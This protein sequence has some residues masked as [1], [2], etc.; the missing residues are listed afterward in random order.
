MIIPPELAQRIVDTAQG[1]VHRNVNIMNREGIIIGTAQPHRRRTF[2][3]GALDV[4][5]MG[6]AV[7][8]AE[9]Q[10]AS[11]PGSRPGVN[12]PIVLE[13]QIIGVIG[14]TGDPAEVR[15]TARLIK[16]ITELIL[17]REL[18]QNMALH[19]LKSTEQIMEYLLWQNTAENL[20]RIRR[21]ARD[22]G[23]DLTLP[24]AAAVADV[25][26]L[27][28]DF[29]A[30]YGTSELVQE[31]AAE[32]ILQRLSEQGLAGPQ[33]AAVIM[34]G[35]LILL[36]I[37]PAAEAPAASRRLAGDLAR[38][39]TEWT[40]GEVFCGIG[41]LAETA[42]DY[43]H[44]H[45]QAEYCL[46]AA[47]SDAPVRSIYEHGLSVGYV[48]HEAASGPAGMV[49]KPLRAAVEGALTQKP[50]LARTL[51]ALLARNLD[52]EA[53]ADALDVHR[54]TL[55]YRLGR[56]REATGLDPMRRLDDAV[57]LRLLTDAA[58]GSPV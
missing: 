29:A 27:L 56:F 50:E 14:V 2:H 26:P 48:L 32:A 58:A 5:E 16:L 35:R 49:L 51:R 20:G 53:A 11:Y 10:T 22:L 6:R 9:D 4:V 1:L 52:G 25:A 15:G 57:I 7:E 17:E 42:G 23:L 37:L 46:R 19:R 28:T 43:A 44:S 54:N 8:I 30:R 55:T 18:L 3:K 31:R 21:L 34:D 13:E 24:R 47:G 38:S 36:K 40:G 12:L 33:D 39:F 45:R 41:A